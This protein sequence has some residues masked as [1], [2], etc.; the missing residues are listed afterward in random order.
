MKTHVQFVSD[1][2][3]LTRNY[4]DTTVR[5]KVTPDLNSVLECSHLYELNHAYGSLVVKIPYTHNGARVRN[6]DRWIRVRNFVRRDEWE[7]EV[8][9]RVS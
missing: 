6:R 7:K 5:V 4:P 2:V 3:W 9:L 8:G 1:G